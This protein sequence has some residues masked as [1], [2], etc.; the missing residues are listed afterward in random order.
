MNALWT[1]KSIKKRPIRAISRMVLWGIVACGLY[2]CGTATP[3]ENESA[4]TSSAPSVP[5]SNDPSWLTSREKLPPP[6]TDRIEYDPKERTLIL[7]DL[8]ARDNWMVQLP[9]GQIG[10]QIGQQYQL[11]E[12]VDL[13]RTYV[14]YSRAGMKI[15]LPVSV[16]KIE[17]SRLGHLSPANGN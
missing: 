14:Y 16:S 1:T 12:G 2:G 8:P 9:D 4:P 13:T 7:Y 11:P 5:G 6:D 17:A 10:H 3:P 15:S